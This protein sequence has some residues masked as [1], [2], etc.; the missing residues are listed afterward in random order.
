MK[1][2]HFWADVRRYNHQ[3]ALHL[4]LTYQSKALILAIKVIAFSLY[5]IWATKMENKIVPKQDIGSNTTVSNSY[6]QFGFSQ[7]C[8]GHKLIILL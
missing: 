4:G 3:F 8:R 6:C 7:V 1:Q 2:A 5:M